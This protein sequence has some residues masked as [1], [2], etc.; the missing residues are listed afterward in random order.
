[1]GLLRGQQRGPG[2]RR[3]S[4]GQPSSQP[5]RR[6]QGRAGLGLSRCLPGIMNVLFLGPL[7]LSLPPLLT[8]VFLTVCRSASTIRGAG[9]PLTVPR[10]AHVSISLVIKTKH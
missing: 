5:G 2:D 7:A 10:E 6:L 9:L 3:V 8:W 4:S 1:M